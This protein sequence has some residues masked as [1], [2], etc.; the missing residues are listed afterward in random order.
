MAAKGRLEKGFV[1]VPSE[2]EAN[3]LHNKGAF[4][5]PQSGGSL[6]LDFLEALYLVE[7]DALAHVMVLADEHV[8]DVEREVLCAILTDHDGRMRPQRVADTL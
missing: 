4:G 6:R 7:V 8:V 5:A 1:V 3:T 2:A